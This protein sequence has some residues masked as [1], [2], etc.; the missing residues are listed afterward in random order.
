MDTT[1]KLRQE[2]I[3]DVFGV[4]QK[5]LV[6]SG[7]KWQTRELL[8]ITVLRHDS[9]CPHCSIP[10]LGEPRFWFKDY[11]NVPLEEIM[12]KEDIDPGLLSKDTIT[13]TK[14]ISIIEGG[15]K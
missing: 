10:L 14:P 11:G 1:P 4:G 13:G 9:Y 2:D 15:E 12:A 3:R 8:G 7:T 6:R 5:V